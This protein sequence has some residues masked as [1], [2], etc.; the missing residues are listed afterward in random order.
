M[1]LN[2][3]EGLPELCAC[4]E[5]RREVPKGHLCVWDLSGNTCVFCEHI[6]GGYMLCVSLSAAYVSQNVY[7][8]AS[9]AGAGG[10]GEGRKAED[11]NREG[12]SDQAPRIPGLGNRDLPPC[13][14]I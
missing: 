13:E 9:A 10:G 7:P 3:P 1:S 14:E 12:R 6:C 2:T 5:R 4:V 11:E 8:A